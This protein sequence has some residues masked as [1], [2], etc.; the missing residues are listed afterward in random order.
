MEVFAT[1][2]FAFGLPGLIFGICAIAGFRKLTE[3]LKAL[4]KEVQALKE[5]GN[6]A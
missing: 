3:E 5:G 6:E 2:G 4:G 1:L